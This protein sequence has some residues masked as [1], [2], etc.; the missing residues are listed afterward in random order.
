MLVSIDRP[1]Y[2]GFVGTLTGVLVSEVISHRHV[3][4][5]N[6]WTVRPLLGVKLFPTYEYVVV[7]LTPVEAE[8]P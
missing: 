2:C 4:G 6:D 3:G 8:I 1:V 7:D 5:V